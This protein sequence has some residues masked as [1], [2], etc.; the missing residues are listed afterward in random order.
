MSMC[1]SRAFCWIN[2]RQ[3]P[4]NLVQTAINAT[5]FASLLSSVEFIRIAGF[6][7]GIYLIDSIY[8]N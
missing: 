1:L 3:V 2:W 5:V 7:S 6:A 8:S 4:G